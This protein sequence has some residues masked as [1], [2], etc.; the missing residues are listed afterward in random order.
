MDKIT[1]CLKT[2]EEKIR[3][4][5]KKEGFICLPEGKIPLKEGKVRGTIE[6]YR[7]I[8]DE[9]FFEKLEERIRNNWEG[10]EFIDLR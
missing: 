10:V 6:L 5:G 7:G 3:V 8:S 4:F 2:I 1:F 9:D